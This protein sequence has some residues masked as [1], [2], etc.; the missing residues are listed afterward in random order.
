MKTIF[1]SIAVLAL[2][3]LLLP[4]A[5]AQ[6]MPPSR[7]EYTAFA[8][9]PQN[10]GNTST[11]MDFSVSVWDGVEPRFQIDINTNTL[12]CTQQIAGNFLFP[13]QVAVDPDVVMFPGSVKFCIVYTAGGHVFA[14]VWQYEDPCVLTLID[15][16]TML[17]GG[18]P[19]C[20]YPNVDQ[21]ENGAAFVWEE[22]GTIKGRYWTTFGTLAS[23]AMGPITDLSP[24]TVGS[25][26]RPDVS[27]YRDGPNDQANIVYINTN[28]SGHTLMLQRY[29]LDDFYAGVGVSCTELSSLHRNA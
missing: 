10:T 18:S 25:N 9:W 29:D 11:G 1:Q 23:P 8:A 13:G 26:H 28:S 7:P 22:E 16:P 24:C 15:G 21:L 3:L 19:I 6:V 12:T 27:V 14:E 20:T 5:N 4:N 17:S 2:L